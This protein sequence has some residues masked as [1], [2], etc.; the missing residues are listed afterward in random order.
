[1]RDAIRDDDDR[2]IEETLERLGFGA[3]QWRLFALCGCGWMSDNSALQCIAVVLPRVRVHFNLGSEIAGL[4]SASMMAGMM[5]G[6]VGWGVV[7]DILGR[8]LPFH[9]TL[10]LTAVFGIA[11]S[12]APNFWVLCICMFFLGTAVGGSMPTDGTLFLENLPHSK[13]YLLTLLSVFFSFGAVLSSVVG[14]FLLPSASCRD[15]DSCD[16]E[17]GANNGWRHVLFTLG[18]INLG[19]AIARSLLFRLHESPRYLVSSGR[20]KEAVV[21]L[22]AIADFNQHSMDIDHNDVRPSQAA[23]DSGV[24][25][26]SNLSGAEEAR[27]LIPPSEDPIMSPPASPMAPLSPH[28]SRSPLTPRS[29]SNRRGGRSKPKFDW[30]HDWQKQMAKLFSPRWRRTVILMWIIWGLMAFA[31]TMFNVWLPSVLESRQGDGDNAIEGALK[32]YVLY[33]AAG[34][35]GSV[36]GAWMIQTKLGRRKSLAVCTL[37]T[38]A[39]MLA[40][41]R[42][43]SKTAS[44]V[45]SMFIS[46]AGTAM[47]AVLYGMTPE[48]F[49]TSIRGTACG[50]SA[51]L[52]RLAGVIAPVVAGVLLAI[53]PTLPLIVTTAVYGVTA[54]CALLLPKS[55]SSRGASGGLM[56]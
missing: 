37:G 20:G 45:S 38:G 33:A 40:F 14:Y 1:M 6:A 3:Y 17:N 52:S 19:C 34:C 11:A 32:E 29:R 12:F 30:L 48:T 42:V 47:Y 53:Q 54:F 25:A 16:F 18:A 36:M 23:G 26:L 35:P 44:T 27:A 49:G 28:S 43:R 51:A 7:S 46:L 39:A 41:I 22:Q 4:L 56:H 9:A 8:A 2:G 10:L 5:L 50:T 31:Y 13:Q 15:H 21:V 55:H 24:S